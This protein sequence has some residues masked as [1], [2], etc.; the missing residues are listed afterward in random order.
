ML[1]RPSPL[2]FDPAAAHY[3]MI[4]TKERYGSVHRV[5]IVCDKENDVVQR[6]MIENNPHDENNPPAEVKDGKPVSSRPLFSK[7]SVH[8]EDDG[9]V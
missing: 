9:T 6:L 1:V 5:Y 8:D 2:F 3:E 7:Y 4:F